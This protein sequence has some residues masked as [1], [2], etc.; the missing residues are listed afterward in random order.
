MPPEREAWDYEVYARCYTEIA[1][2]RGGW[3]FDPG[4]P[5]SEKLQGWY[6]LTSVWDSL[7][8]FALTRFQ[9]DQ[10]LEHTS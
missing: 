2:E 9:L 3:E 7:R 4:G 6:E 8:D 1:R 5:S 10:E